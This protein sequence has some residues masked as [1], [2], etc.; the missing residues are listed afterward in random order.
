LTLKSNSHRSPRGLEKRDVALDQLMEILELDYAVNQDGVV[1]A[2]ELRQFYDQAMAK[3]ETE[4]A[5][6]AL[7]L[8][9]Q[10]PNGF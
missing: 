2:D 5:R 3:G 4:L 7:L 6:E 8:I 9:T 1:S 10:Y